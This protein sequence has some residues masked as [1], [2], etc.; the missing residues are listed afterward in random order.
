VVNSQDAA[1][2]KTQWNSDA[3]TSE[4]YDINGDGLVN[5]LDFAII[6]NNLNKTGE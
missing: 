2:L 5:S 3:T 1:D 6:K 4:A